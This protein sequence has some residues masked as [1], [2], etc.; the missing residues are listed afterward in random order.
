MQPVN[1]QGDF[2]DKNLQPAGDHSINAS[3][4]G[5]NKLG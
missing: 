3:Q 2:L 4:Y 5:Y 1:L